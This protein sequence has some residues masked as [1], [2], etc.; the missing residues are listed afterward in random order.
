ML[1][2]FI[3][4]GLRIYP[5]GI[6]GVEFLEVYLREIYLYVSK[7]RCNPKNPNY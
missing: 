6:R 2:N 5:L 1:T 3:I 4:A 7:T